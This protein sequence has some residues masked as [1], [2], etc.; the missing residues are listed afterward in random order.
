MIFRML[1]FEEIHEPGAEKVLVLI[2]GMKVIVRT[3][4]D[5]DNLLCTVEP[6]EEGLRVRCW[7]QCI[8]RPMQ[9]DYRRLHVVYFPDVVESVSQVKRR[10]EKRKLF[11]RQFGK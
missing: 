11:V 4:F 9:K 7:D 10:K 3:L 6:V 1:W 8:V 2:E 5:K